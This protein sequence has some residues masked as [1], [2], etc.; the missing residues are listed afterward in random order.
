MQCVCRYIKY[1]T[2]VTFSRSYQFVNT[3]RSSMGFLKQSVVV[4]VTAVLFIYIPQLF[5]PNLPPIVEGDFQPEFMD[6]A[7]SFRFGSG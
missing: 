1:T 6:V 5:E 3:D 7:E 4:L 2:R